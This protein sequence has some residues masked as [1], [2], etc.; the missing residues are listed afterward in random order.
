MNIRTTQ[1]SIVGG[2]SC[3]P[4]LLIVEI[5]QHLFV[6]RQCHQIWRETLKERAILL[7]Q[8]RASQLSI[9]INKC[10]AFPSTI[11]AKSENRNNKAKTN[12]L[13]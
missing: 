10:K 11:D 3:S 13:S 7:S 9:F 12:L 2:T 1:E 6:G 5:K 8:K 4:K